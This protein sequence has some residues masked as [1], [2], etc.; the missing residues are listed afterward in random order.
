[1]TNAMNV[2]ADTHTHLYLDA[3]DGDREEVIECAIQAGVNYM[4]LPN[5]D[6]SSILDLGSVLF[7]YPDPKILSLTISEKVDKIL[8]GNLS[9]TAIY[10]P[11]D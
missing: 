5:I 3:F 10:R 4:F 2:F 9:C 1:M 11:P 6:A 7:A 8:R